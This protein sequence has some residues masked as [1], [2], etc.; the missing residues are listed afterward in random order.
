MAE[1]CYPLAMDAI[2][3]NLAN[4][5]RT[6]G[7]PGS[8]V[9]LAHR[10]TGFDSRRLALQA[11]RLV[12]T[13]CPGGRW[14]GN[15]GACTVTQAWDLRDRD[16][17]GARSRTRS[18]LAPLM[19]SRRLKTSHAARSRA[20][21]TPAAREAVRKYRWCSVRRDPHPG[22]AQR[23]MS[24]RDTERH[25]Q[26]E[27]VSTRGSEVCGP[28]SSMRRYNLP[29]IGL[30]SNTIRGAESAGRPKR[31]ACPSAVEVDICDMTIPRKHERMRAGKWQA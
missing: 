2:S 14:A 22:R 9:S 17:S 23:R 5:C 26:D 31:C 15:A 13:G 19:V 16:R 10:S 12:H 6:S 28:C 3:S 18:A 4:D 25:G 29:G 11:R 20:L 30:V 21:M 27:A 1:V 7:A 8:H 24:P